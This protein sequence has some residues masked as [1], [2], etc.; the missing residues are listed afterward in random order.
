VD[1][2]DR[3]L[4]SLEE[5]EGERQH[6]YETQLVLHILKKTGLLHLRVDL[7]ADDGGLTFYDFAVAANFPMWLESKK[8][9]YLHEEKGGTDNLA[10]AMYHRLTKTPVWTAWREISEDVPPDFDEQSCGIVF[11]WPGRTKFAVFHNRLEIPGGRGQYF[12]APKPG[13]P[14][15]VQ[16]LDDLLID[17]GKPEGW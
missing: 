10:D 17:L 16:D 14:M 6:N 15:W 4:P 7:A 3:M 2:T 1:W 13:R 5:M 11:A 8:L 9:K 12:H